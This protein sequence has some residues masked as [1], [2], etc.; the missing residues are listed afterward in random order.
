M[1]FPTPLRQW[2]REPDSE[3]VYQLLTSGGLVADVIDRTQLHTL[4]ERQKAG[5]EDATDR[6]WRLLNLQVW[7]EIFLNGNDA[8]RAGGLLGTGVLTAG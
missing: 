1:G 8:L 7:G 3:P 2:L 6:L 4:L 5:V